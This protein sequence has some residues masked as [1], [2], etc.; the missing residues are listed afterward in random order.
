MSV[1]YIQLLF[2]LKWTMVICE[3]DIATFLSALSGLP[4][5]SVS[6][7]ICF[8]C[9]LTYSKYVPSIFSLSQCY[10]IL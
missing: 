5:T 2:Y 4:S 6:P 9:S 1:R 10:V 3:Q 8:F 7:P